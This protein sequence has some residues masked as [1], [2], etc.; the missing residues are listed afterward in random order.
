MIDKQ[1]HVA[2]TQNSRP[3][4]GYGKRGKRPGLSNKKGRRTRWYVKK[5]LEQ[6][7]PGACPP[8]DANKPIISQALVYYA[9]SSKAAVYSAFPAEVVCRWVW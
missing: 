7:V 2:C 1:A 4:H 5:E 3:E 9:G 6:I 8:M